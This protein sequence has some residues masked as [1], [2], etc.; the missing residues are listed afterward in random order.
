MLSPPTTTPSKSASS[1]ISVFLR[2][3]TTVIFSKS[4]Y[5]LGFL[6][7]LLI[8][9]KLRW[10]ILRVL[11][12]HRR[13]LTNFCASFS[14]RCATARSA[15]F[16]LSRFLRATFLTSISRASCASWSECCTLFGIAYPIPS[17]AVCLTS[18]NQLSHS[19]S[20]S[21]LAPLGLKPWTPDQQKLITEFLH[22]AP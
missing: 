13:F 4:H 21:I 22:T 12:S 15:P 14:P 20:A 3:V 1:G 18:L 9:S 5:T 10:S 16:S 11:T 8:S 2:L 19:A 7:S 6:D 17:S